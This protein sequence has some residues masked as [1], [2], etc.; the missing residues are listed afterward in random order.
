MFMKKLIKELFKEIFRKF[1]FEIKRYYKSQ[2]SQGNKIISLQPDNRSRGNV[3]VSFNIKPFLSS[4][5]VPY[6]DKSHTLYWESYQIVK[7][8]LDY[9]YSVDV[10]NHFNKEF[11]PKKDYL[12]YVETY[13]LL[14][15][16][17]PFLN[18]DCIKIMHTIWAHWLFHNYAEYKRLV[19][20][21]KRKGIVLKPK[22]NLRPHYSCETA[23]FITML[24]NE[25]T[26]NTY[27][28]VKKPVYRI[29]I[30][31]MDIY[32]WPEN[33]NFETC[34]NNFLWLGGLG[35]VHK[36][37]DLVLDAFV[38]MPDYHLYVCGPFQKEEDFEKAYYKELYQ[39]PNIHTAGWID[40]CSPEFIELTNKCIGFIHPSCSEGQSGSVVNCL[41]AGLIPIVSYESGVD[42]SADVGIILKNCSID[43]I[44][45]SIRKISDLSLEE[46]KQK[47]R[48]AWEFARAN[49]TRARFAEEFKNA[50]H[51]I[52]NNKTGLGNQAIIKR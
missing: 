43:E 26:M 5:A 21:Q 23:D 14:D 37:L 3:L 27:S 47:S 44:K 22:R 17:I 45:N 1:G 2:G 15:R 25:F 19:E 35:F 4:N 33:K 18:K 6:F 51:H 31:P 28:H 50:I 52:I 34:R 38:D 36:G 30:A 11:I 24:G 10:V 12:V 48:N 39:T 13:D 7:T 41:H 9:G 20:L 42:V 16:V 49:H 40:V 32:P 29:P 46:L 8:F